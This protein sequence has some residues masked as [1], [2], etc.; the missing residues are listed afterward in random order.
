MSGL[1]LLPQANVAGIFPAGPCRKNT[2]N[3]PALSVVE[4]W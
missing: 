4:G 3:L 1:F 2:G